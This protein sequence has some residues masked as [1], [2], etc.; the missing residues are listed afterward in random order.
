MAILDECEID[1]DEENAVSE[2]RKGTI[3]QSMNERNL[4]RYGSIITER[5][6]EYLMGLDQKETEADKWQ[7]AKLQLREIVKSQGFYITSKGREN[8]LYILL[9]HEMPLYNEKKNKATFRN[10]KQRTRA[11]HMIDQSLLSDEHQKKLEFEI[12][13]NASFEIE[14]SNSLKKRCRY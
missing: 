11:L 9:Q 4:L 12:F 13:R 10:L 5:D 8:D 14:M 2:T 3:I 1:I 6:V 7:F